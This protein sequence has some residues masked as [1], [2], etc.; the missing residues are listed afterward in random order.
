MYFYNDG[1]P[2]LRPANPAVTDRDNPSAEILD[3]TGGFTARC[4]PNPFS[5]LL[6][7]ELQIE[8]DAEVNI[9]VNDVTGRVI[10][11]VYNGLATPG[12]RF[13]WDAANN[14]AGLY[15]VRIEAGANRKVVPVSIVK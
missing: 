1:C 5:E 10:A 7:I 9:T 13:Q 14:P 12:Q 15:F 11:S 6:N 3:H 4:F 8:E 2:V